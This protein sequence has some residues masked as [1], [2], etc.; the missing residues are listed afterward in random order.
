MAFLADL[1]LKLDEMASEASSK[2]SILEQQALY[3]NH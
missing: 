3:W 1:L 2:A